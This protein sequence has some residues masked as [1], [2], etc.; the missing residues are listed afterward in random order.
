MTNKEFNNLY[1]LADV[2]KMIKSRH[3]EICLEY[4][5]NETLEMHAMCPSVNLKLRTQMVINFLTFHVTSNVHYSVHKNPPLDPVLSQLN[6]VHTYI[7]YFH[8]NFI[9]SYAILP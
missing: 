8:V 2:I 6:P 9:H 3:D 4:R 5:E 1:F 7:K